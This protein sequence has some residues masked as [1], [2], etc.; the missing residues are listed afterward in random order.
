MFI[1]TESPL[2]FVR[3]YPVVS[4]IVVVHIIAFL[5]VIIP[6]PLADR[7]LNT[8]VGFNAAIAKGE[9][10]RL[11]TSLFLH[12]QFGHMI[13][14]SFSLLLFGPALEKM[15]GKALFLTAYIGSG[16]LA[17]I[18][19][20]CFAPTIYSHLGASGALFGVFGV[21]SYLALF[22]RRSI[23]REH[24]RIIFSVLVIGFIVTFA[25]PHMNAIAHL[26]GFFSG[27]I[28]APFVAARPNETE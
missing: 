2:T 5:F 26:F 15:I 23:H 4:T 12:V 16:L 18:A 3:S 25:V 17:N 14:N 27:A 6:Y 28:L 9:Y 1:R 22:H 10:W 11:V 24:A 13:A 20:F 7:F 19:T 21:Y 8:F